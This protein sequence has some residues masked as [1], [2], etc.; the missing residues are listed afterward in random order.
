MF[1]I[2]SVLAI[3]LTLR[4]SASPI[5]V[6]SIALPMLLLSILLYLKLKIPYTVLA[7]TVLATFIF[8]FIFSNYYVLENVEPT[9]KYIGK[10]IKFTAIVT[11]EP[12]IYDDYCSVIVKASYNDSEI[13]GI[14]FL[15]QYDGKTLKYNDIIN[16]KLTV[17]EQTYS[18]Y[19][20]D[21]VFLKGYTKKIKIKGNK[22]ENFYSKAIDIRNYIMTVFVGKINDEV[23]GIPIGML[24][25]SRKHISD[26]FDQNIKSVGMTHVM[27]VSGLHISIIC[28]SIVNFIK[29]RFK[30]NNIIPSI[31]GIIIIVVMAAV[32]GFSGSILRAGIMCLSVFIGN[33]FFRRAD[34]LN[35]LG[36]AVTIMVL[37]NPYNIY[38]VSLALSALATLGILLFSEKLFEMLKEIYPFEK[39]LRKPYEYFCGVI[40][41]TLSANLFIIP[42]SILTF[43]YIST[44]SPIVNL[45]L[46]PII[47]LCMLFSL[48][49]VIFSC[50]PILNSIMLYAV[51]II[52]GIFKA[53]VD[54]FSGFTLNAFYADDIMLYIFLA[55]VVSVIILIFVCGR[56]KTMTLILSVV[57]CVLLPIFSIIQENINSNKLKYYFPDSS[58]G[59]A[60]V[61][62]NNEHFVLVVSTNDNSTLWQI[63]SVLNNRLHP[64][65]DY[66]IVPI[67]NKSVYNKVF[68]FF[69]DYG[70]NEY[71]L[72]E[73]NN[74]PDAKIPKESK[75]KIWDTITLSTYN[76]AGGYNLYFE[77]GESRIVFDTFC[78]S[79]KKYDYVVT[80]NPSVSYKINGN[81]PYYVVNSDDDNE[82]YVA[83]LNKL[84]AKALLLSDDEIIFA[85][86]NVNKELNFLR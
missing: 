33:F 73:S 37:I 47:Y 66:V 65:I 76:T 58:N 10:E 35:S 11:E 28:L 1:A 60:M 34:P 31:V 30:L 75:L 46:A 36:L 49:A 50:I 8:T 14:K 67:E 63:K 78:A 44:I 86:Q 80:S 48:F 43:G 12:T 26:E 52:C 51:E 79:A 23:A 72:C 17:K 3:I 54:Y 70:V 24:T 13:D 61:I 56:T 9:K 5:V 38:S 81:K 85:T 62:E 6:L 82:I 53:I 4:Y 18:S 19:C 22:G 77:T 25:G 71:I 2:S 57:L 55:L 7:I 74:Y 27:A 20:A 64:K 68:S 21:K 39:F 45:I 29:K 83:A 59:N 84:G 32:A 69:K 16:C 42:I 40:S 15:L 41:V